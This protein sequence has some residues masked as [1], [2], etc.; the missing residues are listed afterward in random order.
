MEKLHAYPF[1]AQRD[2]TGRDAFSLQARAGELGHDLPQCLGRGIWG[3]GY[4]RYV[5][6]NTYLY[7]CQL[8]YY[9]F[10]TRVS[11]RMRIQLW[12]GTLWESTRG[13]L[14]LRTRRNPFLAR[15]LRFGLY[16]RAGDCGTLPERRPD[17]DA[18]GHE[19]PPL[20]THLTPA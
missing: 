6:R 14:V 2:S 11:T 16:I 13:V 3:C 20:A 1:N 15:M 19:R 10:R 4:R 18:S 17:G 12:C 8:F 9:W 7:V 5:Y